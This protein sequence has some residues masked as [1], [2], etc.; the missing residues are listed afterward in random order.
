MQ[1][2]SENLTKTVTR[3]ESEGKLKALAYASGYAKA[4]L[5]IPFSILEACRDIGRSLLKTSTP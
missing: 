4:P 2:E 3:S 1:K 5:S